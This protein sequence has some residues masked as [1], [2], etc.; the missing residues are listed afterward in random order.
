MTEVERYYD[1]NVSGDVYCG[2]NDFISAIEKYYTIEDQREWEHNID[3]FDKDFADVESYGED[4]E[5]SGVN[6]VAFERTMEKYDDYIE[7]YFRNQDY[8][9][10]S[11]D[12]YGEFVNEFIRNEVVWDTNESGLYEDCWTIFFNKHKLKRKEPKKK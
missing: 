11:L 4:T 8:F 6:F 1:E 10:Y 12:D 7:N 2:Y 3:E 5:F 9:E